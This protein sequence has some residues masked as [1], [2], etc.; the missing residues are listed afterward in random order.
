MGFSLYIC[1][2]SPWLK[3]ITPVQTQICWRWIDCLI[4]LPSNKQ[5]FTEPHQKHQKNGWEKS[6]S[7]KSRRLW[8]HS[9]TKVPW[10]GQRWVYR[11]LLLALNAKACLHCRCTGRS[12]SRVAKVVQANAALHLNEQG[13]AAFSPKAAH[14]QS[15]AHTTP[16]CC[17]HLPLA[18]GFRRSTVWCGQAQSHFDEG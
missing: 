14:P 18:Q 12:T 6:W 2:G 4:F 8:H 9:S 16:V 15:A 3:V 13:C 10:E 1:I 17:S 11:Y 7:H 5:S